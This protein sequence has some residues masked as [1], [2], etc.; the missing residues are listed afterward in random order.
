[1]RIVQVVTRPQRRGAEIFAAQ[2][3][4]QLIK[5]GHQVTLIA[6]FKSEQG[7]DFDG[8]QIKL[9]L[10]SRGKI[11]FKGFKLLAQKLRELNP[12]V[13]QANASEA[14]RMCVGAGYFYKGQ[15]KLIYRNANQISPMLK[16][17]LAKIWNKFLLSQVDG[18]ISV[19]DASRWDVIQTFSLRKRM[20]TI[21]IGVNSEE[22]NQKLAKA[23][24]PI[25]SPYLIQIGSLVPEKDPLGMLEIFK[26]LQIPNLKMVFLGSGPLEDSL[27]DQ[28][29]MLGLSDQVLLIPNQANIFPYLAKASAL[30]MTSKVEGLPGVILEA[31][32]CK[33]PVIAYGVGGIPEILKNG[34]TGWCM[35]PSDSNA[36][37]NSIHEVLTMEAFAKQEILNQAH[38][39]VLSHYTLPQVT[40]QFEDFYKDLL[41]QH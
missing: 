38:H 9:E 1:M 17:R 36:F 23:D 39:L 25:S 34:K 3:S 32:Y 19:S 4:E 40:R 20:V 27:T 6:L 30:V 24:S 8:E 13:V 11:D 29:Q 16:G 18:I 15:Y 2:L 22:I 7:L 28:I 33:V 14:L 41:G 26:E 5:L 10:D 37:I 21:P 12:H 31:M 35:T